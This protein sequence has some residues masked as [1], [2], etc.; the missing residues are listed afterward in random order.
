MNSYNCF[1]KCD[2]HMAYT[3]RKLSKNNN[4]TQ[5]TKNVFLIISENYIAQGK[6]MF[7]L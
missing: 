4:I 2:M 7:T 3:K 1:T 5:H 6:T